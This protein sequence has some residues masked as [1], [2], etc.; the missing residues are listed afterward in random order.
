M[1]KLQ[2]QG[3][4]AG[5]LA[6]GEGKGNVLN[7]EEVEAYFAEEALS[8]EQMELVFDYLLSQKVIV[9]GYVKSGGSVIPA[10]SGENAEAAE[11]KFSAEE[12]QYLKA[13][14]EDLN[15]MPK[16]D[17]LADMLVKVMEMAKEIHHPAVFLGDLIQE[18]NMGLMMAQNEGA[19]EADMLAMARE[20]MQA[21]LESQSEMK[22]R[23]KK[24]ADKVNHLDEQIKKLS[25]E[26]GRKVSV[27]ELTEFLNITEEE[28][29]DI[30]RLA[31]EEIA[32]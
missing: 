10:E 28:V 18:G 22:L 24:M 21:F 31:G 12:G 25:E 8:A 11:R 29:E 26:M 23:D 32:D 2:F 6:L 27:D 1:E 4:L 17:P 5:V 16:G 15:Q 14:E 13:Y 20:S 7:K 3:K 30:L 9:K 19:E